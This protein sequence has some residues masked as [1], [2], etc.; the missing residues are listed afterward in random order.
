MA[1]A[2]ME[3]ATLWLVACCLNQLRYRVAP[4]LRRNY[5]ETLVTQRISNAETRHKSPYLM[6]TI[7][8]KAG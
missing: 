6:G 4:V 3:H 8:P 5:Y 2:G 7:S 1:S